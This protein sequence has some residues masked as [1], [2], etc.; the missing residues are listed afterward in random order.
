[1]DDVTDS[2]TPS[3]ERSQKRTFRTRLA[4]ALDD[5]HDVEYDEL[6]AYVDRRY[7]EL[8][9][10]IMDADMD[11]YEDQLNIVAWKGQQEELVDLLRH[12]SED[13]SI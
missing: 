3:N 12:F 5:T 10:Q 2:S 1:M 6:G 7:E 11:E 13:G 8:Q 4:D 9:E